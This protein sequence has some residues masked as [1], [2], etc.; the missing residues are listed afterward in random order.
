MNRRTLSLAVILL[1]LAGAIAFMVIQPQDARLPQGDLAVGEN[2]PGEDGAPLEMPQGNQP[3][4]APPP[5][6][7]TEDPPGETAESTDKFAESAFDLDKPAPVTLNI[8]DWQRNY[9]VLST[10]EMRLFGRVVNEAGLPVMGAKIIV[11]GWAVADPGPIPEGMTVSPARTSFGD[12]Q[13]A[14]TDA[15]GRFDVYVS[16]PMDFT[17]TAMAGLGVKAVGEYAESP[18]AD[19]DWYEGK[20]DSEIKLVLPAHGGVS[21]RCVDTWGVGATNI[22]VR[23]HDLNGDGAKV[24]QSASVKPD[25]TFEFRNLAPGKYMLSLSTSYWDGPGEEIVF[26]IHPEVISP[27]AFELTLSPRRRLEVNLQKDGKPF[28]GVDLVAQY[29][30]ADGS[31]IEKKCRA[32]NT[33]LLCLLDPPENAERLLVTTDGH[34]TIEVILPQL[35]ERKLYELGTYNMIPLE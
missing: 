6:D 25:G 28:H 11:G 21:G 23:V 29:I 8:P 34:E 16:L 24:V 13:V 32:Y 19:Y 30:L 1:L 22:T 17:K 33:G 15:E 10:V 14:V 26:E 27:L 5:E 4:E 20:K 31:T 9:R 3:L 35:A 7:K 2:T 12:T 18:K